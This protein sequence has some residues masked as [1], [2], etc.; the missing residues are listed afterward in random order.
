[1][2]TYLAEAARPIIRIKNNNFFIDEFNTMGTE[3]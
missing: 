1:M 2:G 3:H